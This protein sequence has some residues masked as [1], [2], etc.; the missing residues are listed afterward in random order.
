V[1]VAGGG[2]ARETVV[3]ISLRLFIP[4]S[5]NEDASP[6]LHDLQGPVTNP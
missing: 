2:E 1:I 5:Q 4:A 3:G 6:D